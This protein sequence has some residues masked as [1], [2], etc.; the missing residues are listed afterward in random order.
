MAE[1]VG[2]ADSGGLAKLSMAR[3]AERLGC[4]TMSLYRHVATKDDLLVLMLDTAYGEP[5]FPEAPVDN[6]R[7][8][9]ELWT[10]Q[11]LAVYQ[12]HP[13]CCRS[14]RPVRLWSPVSCPGWSAVCRC[15]TRRGS[16]PPRSS[17]SYS[18]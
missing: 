14:R 6:W 17:P 5:P 3:L 9:L 11:L 4:A 16:A 7:A 18:S 13:G 8:G 10:T 2:F 15:C 1:A 12:R